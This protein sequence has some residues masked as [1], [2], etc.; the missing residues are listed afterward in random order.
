MAAAR[1]AG[2]DPEVGVGRSVTERLERAGPVDGREAARRQR[3]QS[4]TVGRRNGRGRQFPSVHFFVN[5]VL[6]FAR[7]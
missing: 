6:V 3:E 5:F 2:W 4:C 1:E 7:A